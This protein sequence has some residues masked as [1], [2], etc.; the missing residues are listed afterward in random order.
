MM[1]KDRSV[2][3]LNSLKGFLMRLFSLRFFKKI[4]FFRLS[5]LSYTGTERT[6]LPTAI[7]I[8]TF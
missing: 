7:L 3:F 1:I 2:S 6:A 8:R 4:A 5:F